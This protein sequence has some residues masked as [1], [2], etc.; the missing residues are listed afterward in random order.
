MAQH[1]LLNDDGNAT[2]NYRLEGSSDG[3]A[4]AAL[5][6][7]EGVRVPAEG[8][9]TDITAVLPTTILGTSAT[10]QT[11]WMQVNDSSR[12][13]R[14]WVEIRTPATTA[15]SGGTGQ[16]IPGGLDSMP[17]IYDGLKWVG[18]YSQFT[19]PGRYDVYYYARD[20][21]TGDT[22]PMA[23][24]VIY[25]KKPGNTAPSAFTLSTPATASQ[26]KLPF[27]LAWKE[28]NDSDGKTYS[29]IVA[30][31]PNFSTVVYR[32]DDIP[33]GATIL[34][35]S[36]LRDP[37]NPG[38]YYCQ[39]NN[40]SCWWKVRAIDDFGEETWSDS[41]NFKVLMSNVLSVMIKAYVTSG[42]LPV[43]DAS[44]SVSSGDS[45][46]SLP[47]GLCLMT[48]SSLPV[49]ASFSAAGYTAQ[50]S[51]AVPDPVDNVS[52]LPVSLTPA[53]TT[54]TLTL[55]IA[56]SG[57][58]LVNCSKGI[59]SVGCN[60]TFSASD[61]ISLL[62]TNDWKTMPVSWG[63]SCS[64]SI[65]PSCSLLMDSDRSVI[66][67]FNPNYQAR[68]VSPPYSSGSLQ[69]ALNNAGNG[70]TVEAMDYDFLEP[71]LFDRSS[72]EVSIDGGR[73]YPGYSLPTTGYSSVQGSFRIKQGTIK[74][75]GPIAVR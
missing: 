14:A 38:F 5:Y 72:F 75:K 11:L 33:V 49:T 16:V 74:V 47:T 50:S 61:T 36:A 9:P 62:A 37:V 53:V 63:G 42:G 18:D 6:L 70:A 23:H 24:T 46:V 69:D 35:E 39:N 67:T 31:D 4:S 68:I 56:G 60:G 28:S 45:V 57:N 59:E 13:E 1:P 41:R 51:V 64:G 54:H 10:S 20:N 43:S 44:C 66:A 32:E 12:V 58:G 52:L 19:D 3:I 26:M 40:A 15:S 21:Q 27:P 73:G 22:S 17:L 34:P 29:L 71:V 65:P 7:G 30:T 8:N 2:G 25:K 55:A 48:T